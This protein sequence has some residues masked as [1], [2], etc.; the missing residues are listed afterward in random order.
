MQNNLKVSL[1]AAQLL[2]DL[3]SHD[4][5][6]RQPVTVSHSSP[7]KPALPAG[8]SPSSPTGLKIASAGD[9]QSPVGT[10]NGDH[11]SDSQP[12]E[13][14]LIHAVLTLLIA[15]ASLP[16]TC[17][18]KMISLHSHGRAAAHNHRLLEC[19]YI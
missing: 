11:A 13:G 10:E 9:Q 14:R 4:P 1:E 7:V 17:P 19:M 3:L 16:V 6:S 2:Q 15:S 18:H 5:F 8:A 12:E